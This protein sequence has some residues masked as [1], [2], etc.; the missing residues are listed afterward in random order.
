M[1]VRICRDEE[2]WSKLAARCSYGSIFHDW[3]FLKTVEKHT[4]SKLHPLIGLDGTNPVG[5]YPLFYMKKFLL[6]A[7]FSP[8]PH[9]AVPYLGPLILDYDILKLSK[10][11]S[12]FLEF[13]KAVDDYIATELKASYTFIITAPGLSDSRPM[14]WSNYALEPYYNYR[15]DLS[16]GIENARNRLAKK[17]RSGISREMEKGVV[18]REGTREDLGKLCDL[19][20]GRYQEQG[21]ALKL[22]KEYILELYDILSPDHMK[23]LCVEDGGEVACG[24]VDLYYR[25]KAYGWIGNPKPKT[26]TRDLNDVLQWESIVSAYKNNCTT[27]EELGANTERLCRYKSKYGPDL[28]LHYSAKKSGLCGRMAEKAYVKI[29]KP[30]GGSIV[31]N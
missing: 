26:C 19:L 15:I 8:P 20:S 16:K 11:Q 14:R 10:K 30:L 13:Q 29:W 6:G 24:L 4:G 7:V 25:G 2:E 17:L 3:K 31:R 21:M 18:V 1:S 22:S 27:Y 23:I 12:I 9:A 5:L 28:V